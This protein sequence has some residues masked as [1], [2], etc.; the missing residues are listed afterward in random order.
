MDGTLIA[1]V[2]VVVVVLTFFLVRASSQHGRDQLTKE[3]DVE[4]KKQEAAAEKV[5]EEVTSSTRDELRA[6]GS[7]W[8]RKP[9]SAG[10]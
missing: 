7:K 9:P 4:V 8:V 2:A 3:I 5:D 1:V 10:P 6:R